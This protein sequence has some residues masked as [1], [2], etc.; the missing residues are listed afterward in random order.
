MFRSRIRR[1]GAPQVASKYTERVSI[2]LTKKEKEN[3]LHAVE[4]SN[5]KNIPE[6]VRD[7]IDYVCDIMEDETRQVNIIVQLA[8]ND[9]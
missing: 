5:Y 6:M 4:V 7:I 2:P 8:D 1:N 9:E 3:W